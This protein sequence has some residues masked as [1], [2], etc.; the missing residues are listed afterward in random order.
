MK[1]LAAAM[2]IHFF[3]CERIIQI[4]FTEAHSPSFDWRLDQ[5]GRRDDC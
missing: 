3:L 5:P 2:A 1:H 4:V